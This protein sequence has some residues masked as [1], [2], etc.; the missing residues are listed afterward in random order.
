MPRTKI[1]ESSPEP[2]PEPLPEPD[3]GLTVE[4][5]CLMKKTCVAKKPATMI[6]DTANGAN[7]D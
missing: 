4:D 7:E 2:L 1:G 6:T 3:D 5:L